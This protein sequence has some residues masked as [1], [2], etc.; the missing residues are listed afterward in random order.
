MLPHWQSGFDIIAQSHGSD[1]DIHFLEANSIDI[2]K[3]YPYGPTCRFR[4]VD[5]PTLCL[6]VPHGGITGETLK[7]ILKSLD[8]LGV[9]QR[10]PG[11][12][13]HL[14]VDGHGSRF[15]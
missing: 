3:I 1:D 6:A 8:D 5:V 11:L 10:G 15:A 12:M 9:T 13:P 7:L 2:G 4:G 14:Q